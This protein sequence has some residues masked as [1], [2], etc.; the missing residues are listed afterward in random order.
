MRPMNQKC[1]GPLFIAGHEVA[2]AYNA[3]VQA[4]LDNPELSRW[5]YILT[6]ED[7]V[8]PPPDG[9][10]KLYESLEG[11]VCTC[12]KDCKPDER[13]RVKCGVKLDCVQGLYWTKGYEGQPMI[14]GDPETM[15][16]NFVPQQVKP[17][18]VQKCNGLG[19]GFNLFR[20]SMFKDK[21]LRKPWFKTEQTWEEGKGAKGFTQDLYFFDDA[22]SKGFKF[23][24]D[25]RVLCGHYDD[26][27]D[28]VW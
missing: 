12:G 26:G 20:V 27:E 3:A 6:F 25:T 11:G 28:K 16:K 13:G 4:I 2:E 19:M 15:P 22:G 14:Y 17:G 21:S 8:I 5:R 23:A 9:L 1:I 10:L 18:T 7:D 24:C